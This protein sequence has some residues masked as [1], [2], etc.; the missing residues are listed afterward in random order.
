MSYK[1]L[2]LPRA[3]KQIADLPEQQANAAEVAIRSLE[4]NPRP[5]GCKK[6]AGREG[7]RIRF[8]SYRILYKI[9]D[10]GRTVTVTD[11]G[12]RREIYR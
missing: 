10:L 2:I 4:A 8:G 9:D 6:L 1:L 7:W 11:V 12:H 5:S 3:Q